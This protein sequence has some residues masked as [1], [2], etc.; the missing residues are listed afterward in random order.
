MTEVIPRAGGTTWTAPATVGDQREDIA[1]TRKCT[2]E[3]VGLWMTVSLVAGCGPSAPTEGDTGPSDVPVLD[4]GTGDTSGLDAGVDAPAPDGGA[5]PEACAGGVDEDHDLAVDCADSECWTATHC[6]AADVAAH[7]APGLVPCGAPI[8]VDEAASRAACASIGTPLGVTDPTDCTIGSL[9]ATAQVFCEE[10][11]GAPA[12]LWIAETSTTPRSSEMLTP[13]TLRS[14]DFERGSADWEQQSSADGSRSG[15][16]LPLHDGAVFGAM[17]TTFTV[18][19]V[20]TVAPGDAVSRLLR[21]Q[22]VTSTIDVDAMMSSDTR[23]PLYLGG[24][25]VAV[26]R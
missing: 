26:P 3:C 22:E 13:R 20:R 25:T 4:T 2:F 7:A 9:T 8:V 12:A 19:T 11:S 15:A 10:G 21:M 23:R 5:G 24:L 18:V 17:Q 1:V 16:S 6:A 14:I